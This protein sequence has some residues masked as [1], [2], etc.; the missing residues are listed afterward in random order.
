M[1]PY[2]AP[3]WGEL[4]KYHWPTILLGVIVWCALISLFAWLL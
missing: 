1:R 3:S 4:L 2:I